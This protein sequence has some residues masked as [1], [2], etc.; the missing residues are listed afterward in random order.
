MGAH[1]PPRRRMP[2]MLDVTFDEL[3]ACTE[4]DLLADQP[5]FGVNQSHYVL[6]LIAKAVGAARL[7]VSAARPQPAG[8]RLVYQPAVGQ[9]VECRIGRFYLYRGKRL[10]PM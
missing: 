2:P 9:H 3:T 6:Q 8:E 1:A 5:R 10:S 7:I 4:H